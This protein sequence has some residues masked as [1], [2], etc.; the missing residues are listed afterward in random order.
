VGSGLVNVTDVK[1]GSYLANYGEYVQ[2]NS[3]AGTMTIFLPMASGA[4]GQSVTV[5]KI[6]T[7]ANSILVQR[8]QATGTTETIDGVTGAYPVV[9]AWTSVVV[10]SNGL[11]WLA[12]PP[13]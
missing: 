13:L 6:S 12:H 1:T 9:G 7:G 10:V 2:A 4:T 11:A 8:T 5:K 3:T